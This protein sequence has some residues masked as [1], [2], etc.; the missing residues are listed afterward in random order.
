ML[1]VRF[2]V[3]LYDVPPDDGIITAFDS[4]GPNIFIGTDKGA[5]HKFVVEDSQKIAAS[6]PSASSPAD[7]QPAAGEA[8]STKPVGGG[9]ASSIFT[10]HVGTIPSVVP[11]EKKRISRLQHSRTH[12]ILFVVCSKKLIAI[13]SNTM[14]VLQVIAEGIGAFHVSSAKS[15]A[16]PQQ[17]RSKSVGPAGGGEEPQRPVDVSNLSLASSGS[18]NSGNNKIVHIVCAAEKHGRGVSVFQ[19]EFV[20]SLSD[21]KSKIVMSKLQELVLPETVDQIVEFNGM[22]CVGLR[23][24]YSMLSLKDGDARS[25]LALG[26]KHPLMGLGDGEVFLRLHQNVFVVS[27]KS[28]PS[29]GHTL[30]RTVR[31]D[32]EPS[33]LVF[34]HP[35]LFSFSDQYCDVFSLYDDDVVERLPIPGVIF[36]SRFGTNDTIYAASENKLWMLRTHSLRSQLAGLVQRYKVNDAFHLL[37]QQRRTAA[38]FSTLERELNIMAGFAHLYHGRATDAMQHFAGYIDVR[39]LLRHL[40]ELCPN[41]VRRRLRNGSSPVDGTIDDG[42][43]NEGASFLRDWENEA[44]ARSSSVDRGLWTS[45]EDERAYEDGWSRGSPYNRIGILAP[46]SAGPA[47]EPQQLL[48]S[49]TVS[50]S[51]SSGSSRVRSGKSISMMFGSSTKGSAAVVGCTIDELW[52]IVF[53]EHPEP[54]VQA[55]EQQ[56]AKGK[57]VRIVPEMGGP[58]SETVFLETCR[59]DLKRDLGCYLASTLP[60]MNRDQRRAAEFALLAL[61]LQSRDTASAFQVIRSST[62]LCIREA[63]PLLHATCEWRLLALLLDKKGLSNRADELIAS[64][65]LVS[66]YLACPVDCAPVPSVREDSDVGN[67]AAPTHVRKRKALSITTAPLDQSNEDEAMRSFF[68]EYDSKY[69]NADEARLRT[70]LTT[71]NPS[72]SPSARSDCSIVSTERNGSLQELFCAVDHLDV[73]HI[74]SSIRK[75]PL[76]LYASDSEGSSPLMVA[77]S[78]LGSGSAS[79]MDAVFA[80]ASLLI[81]SGCKLSP[82][83]AKGWDVTSICRM[84]ADRTVSSLLLSYMASCCF[85]RSMTIGSS[86]SLSF[87]Q[88]A[89]RAKPPTELLMNSSSPAVAVG[90]RGCDPLVWKRYGSWHGYVVNSQSLPH[91]SQGHQ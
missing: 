53:Y 31:F 47:S 86:A 83:N 21:G 28:M 39:E 66:S 81:D 20:P 62:A 75:S 80:V 48:P 87:P 42:T 79:Q 35:F 63:Y 12:P 29:A 38:S 9:D 46:S 68:A 49:S 41:V 44:A 64:R 19:V 55:K 25:I 23:R 84:V 2:V 22:L 11:Q 33:C 57:N 43:E 90:L 74:E 34:R 60:N 17:Q 58:T 10:T 13:D 61:S 73:V 1:A 71:P 78:L 40:P 32:H 91:L 27:M 6:S 8:G 36:G 26:G 59:R 56:E 30:K 16:P 77:V 4:F 72:P 82:K 3:K 89:F 14:T 65:L 7:S 69:A 51:R 37:S 70:E 45:D 54:P 85:V 67:A 88:I 18:T 5:I 52:K 50:N 24:E 15:H 76:A